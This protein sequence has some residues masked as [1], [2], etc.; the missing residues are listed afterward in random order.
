MWDKR[1]TPTWLLSPFRQ[2]KRTI[3]FPEPPFLGAK[4]PHLPQ[5]PPCAPGPSPALLSFFGHAPAPFSQQALFDSY[6]IFTLALQPSHLRSSFC[7]FLFSAPSAQQGMPG[8]HFNADPGLQV[9]S[10]PCTPTR[11]RPP[12]FCYRSTPSAPN[13]LIQA[14]SLCRLLL[15]R[16]NWVPTPVSRSTLTPA[17]QSREH[18]CET[19]LPGPGRAYSIYRCLQEVS[20]H[21]NSR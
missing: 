20:Q 1:L 19:L 21:W 8:M 13:P 6:H 4:Q 2:L 17:H 11:A 12:F 3:R 14:L 18:P 7:T 16:Q 9:F 5:P 15:S 10:F